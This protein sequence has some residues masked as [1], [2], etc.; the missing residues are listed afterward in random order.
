MCKYL[1]GCREIAEDERK[2]GSVQLDS[3]LLFI[4]ARSIGNYA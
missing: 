1:M 2:Q 4:G 3:P